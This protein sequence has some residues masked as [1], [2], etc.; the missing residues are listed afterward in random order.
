MKK[1]KLHLSSTKSIWADVLTNEKDQAKGYMYVEKI[2]DN[3]G[4]LF[5][6]HKPSSKSF[7]MKNV[8]VPLDVV[9]L[10]SNGKILDVVT[11]QPSF[12][13]KIINQTTTPS[14]TY[15]VLEVRGGLMKKHGVKKGM[16]IIASNSGN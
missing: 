4:K 5:V 11:L 14:G 1:I 16:R 15:C 2:P 8:K 9:S 12:G 7:W 3:E 6:Y 10:D 13:K